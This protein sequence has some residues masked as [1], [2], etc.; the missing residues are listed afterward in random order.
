MAPR[1]SSRVFIPSHPSQ[2]GGCF[3]FHA[4][5]EVSGLVHVHVVELA[6]EGV[7]LPPLLGRLVEADLVE[8]PIP[9]DDAALS[10]ELEVSVHHGREEIHVQV[11]QRAPLESHHQL[12]HVVGVLVELRDLVDEGEDLRRL[13]QMPA[14]VVH[15][16]ALVEDGAPT[17]RG[18]RHVELPRRPALI[19]RGDVVRVLRPRDKDIPDAALLQELLH[20]VHG[21]PVPPVV[22]SH[23]RLARTVAVAKERGEAVQVMGD[24]LLDQEVSAGIE[25]GSTD[26]HVAVGRRADDDPLGPLDALLHRLDHA[27]GGEE[28]ARAVARC[29]VHVLDGDLGADG[30]EVPGMPA[31][32]RAGPHDCDALLHDLLAIPRAVTFRQA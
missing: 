16:V 2:A 5:D 24:R 22:G 30:Q 28:S 8:R 15:R 17:L 9:S 18:H 32:D 12:A 26:G 14:H 10:D 4:R 20:L 7:H 1:Q 3:P 11:R 29:R 23:H 6:G 13:A 21:R 27:R 25:R 31:P 19:A